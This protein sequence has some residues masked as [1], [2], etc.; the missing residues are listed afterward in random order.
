MLTLFPQRGYRVC[1]VFVE[2][3]VG[4]Q[5]AVKRWYEPDALYLCDFWVVVLFRM[6]AS[7]RCQSLPEVYQGIGTGG[8]TN[9]YK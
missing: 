4:D 9:G 1:Q 6:P 3:P 8:E 7:L 5:H 2:T